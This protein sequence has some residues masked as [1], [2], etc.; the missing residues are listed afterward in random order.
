MKE[1][2]IVNFK[3]NEKEITITHFVDA[4]SACSFACSLHMVNEDPHVITI[5]HGEFRHIILEKV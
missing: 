5:I 1:N 4:I 2:Y 3:S